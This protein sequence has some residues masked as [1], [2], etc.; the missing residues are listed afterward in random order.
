MQ[1][2]SLLQ[3]AETSTSFDQLAQP[4]PPEGPS[5]DMS[6]KKLYQPILIDLGKDTWPLELFVDPLSLLY[7][8]PLSLLSLNSG[9]H[10]G[11]ALS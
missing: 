8:K 5:Q 10:S 4:E 7:D 2:N 3:I 1:A 9:E 6:H 11:R